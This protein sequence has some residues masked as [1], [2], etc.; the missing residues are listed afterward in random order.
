MASY[1]ASWGRVTIRSS[2]LPL[3]LI[4]HSWSLQLTCICI[5]FTMPHV[6]ESGFQNKEMFCLWNREYSSR[7]LDSHQQLEYGIQIPLTKTRIQ[8]LGPKFKT[9]NPEF[10]TVL[11]YPFIY[12]GQ[13][14]DRGEDWFKKKNTSLKNRKS[15][16][17]GFFN[18]KGEGKIWVVQTYT[19]SLWIGDH[20]FV[21]Q[22]WNWFI[23]S[24]MNI[25]QVNDGS[26]NG[27]QL[28]NFL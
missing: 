13:D 9:W 2:P 14:V 21:T 18:S 7:T 5:I 25:S 22:M 4:L 1:K 26:Q 15:G 24:E 10:K 6:R 3:L 11:D 16:S 8:Y 12:M 28:W 19:Q 23:L 17:G 20:A 27:K